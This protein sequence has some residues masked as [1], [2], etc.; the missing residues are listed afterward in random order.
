MNANSGISNTGAFIRE[1]MFNLGLGTDSYKIPVG[2]WRFI[3]IQSKVTPGNTDI[4]QLKN[5]D[6]LTIWSYN[7][8][9]GYTYFYNLLSDWTLGWGEFYV[10]SDG[11]AS[12]EVDTLN[13][14]F[15]FILIKIG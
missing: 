15:E 4:L 10:A 14:K 5:S 6:G 1:E 9:A 2:L 12:V 11:N 8:G 13:T 7:A 3:P